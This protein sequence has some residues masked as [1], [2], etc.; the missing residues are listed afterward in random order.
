MPGDGTTSAETGKKLVAIAVPVGHRA[1][2]TPE[3]EISYR[4]LLHYLGGYD[5]YVVAPRGLDIAWDGFGV[6]RFDSRYF[7]S[8]DAY[9]RLILDRR[10]YE[11]FQDYEHVLIYHLDALVF[12]DELEEWC[13]AGYDF[14]GAPLL[15]DPER[16]EEGF[17]LVGNGGF[18]L[19]RVSSCLTVIDS[20]EYEVPPAEYW[21]R[22]FADEPWHVRLRGLPRTILKGIRALNGPRWEMSRWEGNC[23]IFFA[24][25]ATHYHPGFRIA[26]F[27]AALRFAF[28]CAPRYCFERNGRRLPFGCHAWARYDRRFWEPYLLK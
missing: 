13:R 23:D 25:R 10:F 27:D 3:E 11:A 8:A 5:R 15:K 4:H 18:S 24:R 19:R 7:G 6:K 2:R 22:Y 16:P 9:K 26:P 17:K 21:E 20:P 28:E 1:E 12:R 14:I